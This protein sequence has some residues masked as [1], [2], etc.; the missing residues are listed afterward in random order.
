MRTPARRS[1]WTGCSTWLSLA[2][3]LLAATD[4]AVDQVARQVGYGSGFALSA[5]I[6]RVRGVSPQQHRRA[7]RAG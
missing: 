4:D 5:A 7:A 1:C 6:K 3:D 2:A